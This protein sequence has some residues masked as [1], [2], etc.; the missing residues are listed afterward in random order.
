MK[1][2][3]I[4]ATTFN[5][6]TVRMTTELC[7]DPPVFT[8]HSQNFTTEEEIRKLILFNIEKENECDPG[9]PI[10]IILVNNDVGNVAGNKF[11]QD[12]NGKKLKNGKIISMQNDNYGWS[13]GAF[14]KGFE[15]V[16][17]DYDYFIFT[18]DDVI[19][20]KKNYAKISF[21][22]FTENKNCGFV[23]FWGISNFKDRSVSN[24]NLVHAHG[25]SGFSSKK[26]LDRVFNKYGKLPHSD[27][28]DKKYYKDI[29]IDGEIKFTNVILKMGYNLVEAPEKLFTPAYDLMRGINKPWKPTKFVKYKWIITKKVRKYIYELLIFIKLYNT[30]KLI[31]KFLFKF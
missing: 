27:F 19:I 31:R 20:A 15:E 26:V 17:N 12:L 16:R 8:L 1:I 9:L 18:E 7:G 24:E 22:T 25:A 14:S 13:Y 6:R 4:I 30:Y 3:K 10:D 2:A 29:I 28:S 5:Y 23:S 21:K 11:V